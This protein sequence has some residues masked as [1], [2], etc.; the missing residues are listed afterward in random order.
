[1]TEVATQRVFQKPKGSFFL[2]GPRATG[3]STWIKLQLKPDFTIDLLKA[4][5]FT[6]YSTNPG[7]LREIIEANLNYKVIVIDEIQKL[8]ELLN[9][10]HSLIFDYENKLQFVLTGSSARKLKKSNVNLLA[11]R[12]ANRS[13][14]SYSYLEIKEK[15]QIDLAL[16]YGLL[17]Q[18]WNIEDEEEKKDYLISYVDLYLKEEIM[19]EAAVRSL[20]S[21]MLFLEH[22]A[23][24]NGQVLNIQNLAQEIGIPRTTINGYLDLLEQTLLGYKLAPIHLQAKVKEV[25]TPKFYFFDPGVVRALA[26]NIDENLGQDKGFLLETLV[27]HELK[28]FSDYFQKRWEIFYW[29]T[30]SENEVDFVITKAKKRIGIEVKSSKNWT[31]DFN[32]GLHSLLE[33]KTISKGYGIYLGKEKIKV[34]QVMVYPV[35]QFIEEMHKGV[36]SL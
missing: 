33:A 19:Q 28:L 29:G 7:R 5:D 23:L 14:H 12:A 9:E 6:T 35:A 18:V 8:P 13:F 16:K 32:Q 21:Y 25:S 11:G 31:A 34:G 1:M 24:R 36:I 10:V 4:R 15:F 2:L 30:P 3:K 26:K 27:L 20:P 22:F 17:P